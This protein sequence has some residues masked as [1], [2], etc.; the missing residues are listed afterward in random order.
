MTENTDNNKLTTPIGGAVAL[1]YDYGA[2]AATG[3]DLDMGDLSIP[4]VSLAQKDSK[5]LDE[6][7]ESYVPGGA[8]GMLFNSAEKRYHESLL[9]VPAFRKTS[10]VEFLPDRGGFVAEHEVGSPE[11]RDAKLNAVSKF[12]LYSQAGNPLVETKSLYAIVLDPETLEPTGYVI[13]PFTSSKMA[14]W[15]DYWTQIDTA[16]VSKSAP[17]FAH[18]VWLTARNE[19]NKKGD[20]YHNF[21]M[22]PA[23]DE[24][25]ELLPGTADSSALGAVRT[26]MLSPESTGYLAGRTLY[27]AVSEGRARPDHASD[28]EVDA[29]GVI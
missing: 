19:R 11:V 28:I 20:K 4:L 3:M 29:G 21:V 8:P 18:A 10:Y 13:V 16:R 25:G 23:F 24:S 14:R 17:I 26:S 6:D 12:E 1:P 9:L 27:T 15:R 7:E 5:I 22:F 2:D